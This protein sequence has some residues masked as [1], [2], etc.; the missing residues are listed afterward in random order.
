MLLQP[1]NNI[2][3]AAKVDIFISL[4]GTNQK[5]YKVLRSLATPKKSS[6]KT[7]DLKTVC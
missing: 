4:A 2:H 6:E 1:A 7:V 5:M 3:D